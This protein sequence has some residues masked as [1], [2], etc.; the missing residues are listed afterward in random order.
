VEGD[1]HCHRASGARARAGAERAEAELEHAADIPTSAAVAEAEPVLE[2]T[3]VAAPAG[4]IRGNAGKMRDLGRG[5]EDDVALWD[6]R[7]GNEN[8]E[9][10]GANCVL[11]MKIFL[12]HPL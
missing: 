3:D 11:G 9:S 1:G 7:V 8:G 10:A 2:Y 12:L 5:G 4:R 6:P